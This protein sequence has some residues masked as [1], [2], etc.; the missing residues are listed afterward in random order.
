VSVTPKP[1]RADGVCESTIFGARFFGCCGQHNPTHFRR[2]FC[3]G[4]WLPRAGPPRKQLLVLGAAAT[5]FRVPETEGQ[6]R[7]NVCTSIESLFIGFIGSDA[8]RKAANAT[9]IAIFSLATKISWKNDAGSW[10]A[11][12]EW[13]RCVAVGKLADFAGSFTKGAH[14]AIEANSVAAKTSANSLSAR[15]RPQSP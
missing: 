7:I 13:H 1:G 8:E 10:E 12:T 15:R 9:N 4:F 6:K 14:I 2:G 5:R 3:G 11:R